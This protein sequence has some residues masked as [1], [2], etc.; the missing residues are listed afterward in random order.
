MIVAC[1]ALADRCSALLQAYGVPADRARTVAEAQ[2][3][4]EAFGVGTHGLTVLLHILDRLRD[5][6]L[7]PDRPPQVE[8]RSALI[9]RI[10]GRGC[11]PVEGYLAACA[12]AEASARQHGLGFASLVAT[13]WIGALGYHLAGAARRGMLCLAWAQMSGQHTV[14][15]HGGRE[16]RLSTDPQ[17]LAIPHPGD[18]VIADFSTAATSNG[19]INALISRQ[20]R[21]PETILVDREGVPTDDPRVVREGGAILPWGGVHSGFRGTALA[22]WIEALTAA[23]GGLPSNPQGHGGQNAHVLMLQIGQLG[24][25][26][27][28]D[29]RIA[30]LTAWLRSSAPMAGCQGPQLPGAGGWARHAA[31]Q[32]DGLR[33]DDHHLRLLR[34][35]AERHGLPPPA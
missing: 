11:I 30:D 33:L 34:S 18:P 32:A 21:A 5:G 14:A 17:A 3:G 7:Q 13:G 31:A 22:L 9:A 8:Q 20:A 15:P 2:V 19:R 24:G 26:D 16:A 23:V 4:V 10:E 1:S 6:G 29:R 25:A 27:G 28:Y 12:A 35:H